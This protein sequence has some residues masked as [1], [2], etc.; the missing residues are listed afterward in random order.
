MLSALQRLARSASETLGRES[1]V[2]RGLRPAYE[3]LLGALTRGGGVP[4]TINGVTFRVDPHYRRTF[5]PDY[6][7][8]LAALLKRRIRPGATCIDAGANMGVYVL[9]LAWWSRPYGRV[10]AFEP[11]PA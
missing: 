10:I 7:P 6:D 1:V 3:S 2:V 4:M 9:Q 11:N 8:A 5:A